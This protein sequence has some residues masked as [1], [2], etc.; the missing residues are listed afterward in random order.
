MVFPRHCFL[1]FDRM[2][3]RFILAQI[4][5]SFDNGTGN[6]VKDVNCM[7]SLRGSPL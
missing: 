3:T 5:V 1:Q 4:H 2:D 7:M 6:L